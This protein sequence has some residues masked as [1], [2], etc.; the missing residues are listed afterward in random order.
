M[1]IVNRIG[2][3]ARL[4][5]LNIKNFAERAGLAYNTAHDLYT[6]RVSRIGLDVLDKVCRVL[7]MQPGELLVWVD[8]DPPQ[9]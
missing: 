3:A 2:E 7:K 6:G 1:T 5:D 4:Q 9:N 8:D